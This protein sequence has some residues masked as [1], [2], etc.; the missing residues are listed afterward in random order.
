MD[1]EAFC[2]A[3]I[4]DLV[5]SLNFD[6]MVSAAEAPKLR[7]T[8]GLRTIRNLGRVSSFHASL[9]LN[10][11]RVFWPSIAMVHSPIKPISNG[12]I[13]LCDAKF[14]LATA[15]QPG[16]DEVENSIHKLG[17]NWTHIF[18]GE[19]RPDQSDSAVYVV[20]YSTRA[21]QALVIVSGCHATYRKAVPFMSIWHRDCVFANPI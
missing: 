9:F 7:S 16:R 19:V 6:E 21:D 15:S 8:P 2:D 17:E 12:T 10:R 5:R 1:A 18:L 14:D 4:E 20:T 11:L 3:L 13:Q